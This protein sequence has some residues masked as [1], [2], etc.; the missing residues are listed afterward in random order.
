ML[1]PSDPSNSLLVTVILSYNKVH[2]YMLFGFVPF[3][4]VTGVACF[5]SSPSSTGRHS[6]T[7][8]CNDW[9]EMDCHFAYRCR[10]DL[11]RGS[12]P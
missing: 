2:R 7:C 5:F 6:S 4:V 11:A 10:P 9:M 3:V 12:C 1:R 8:P